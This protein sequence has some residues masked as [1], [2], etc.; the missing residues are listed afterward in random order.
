MGV[1]D[2]LTCMLTLVFCL[3]VSNGLSAATEGVATRVSLAGFMKK[4][5]KGLCRARLLLLS[6]FYVYLCQ[7]F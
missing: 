1:T 2:L 7:L 6:V 3:D 5:F 4:T